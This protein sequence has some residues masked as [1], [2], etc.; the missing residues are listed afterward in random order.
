MHGG[1]LYGFDSLL[2]LFP[3]AETGVYVAINGPMGDTAQIAVLVLNQYISDLML[4]LP[5]WLNQ[6]TLCSYPF[7]WKKREEYIPKT[8]HIPIDK[9][10]KS[11]RSLTVYKGKYVSKALGTLTMNEKTENGNSFLFLKFG[12]RGRFNLYPTRKKDRFR[13]EAIGSISFL[14]KMDFSAPSVWLNVDFIPNE[15][16]RSIIDKISLNFLETGSPVVFK[17]QLSPS[18]VTSLLKNH[19][20]M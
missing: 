11:H 6:S 17:R 12:K 14:S 5:P 2:T 9:T 10:L 4:G 16:N 15:N 18:M 19:L 1:I 3:E 13:A 7:P 8:F 20:I